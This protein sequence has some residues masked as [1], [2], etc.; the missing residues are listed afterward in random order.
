LSSS[1]MPFALLV[2]IRRRAKT[3]LHQRELKAG[4][5]IRRRAGR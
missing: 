2:S 1:P 5:G 4:L 3:V